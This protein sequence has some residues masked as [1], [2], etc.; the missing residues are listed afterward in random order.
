MISF[1]NLG[2]YGRL[3]NQMF[4]Y[5]ALR[6]IAA[7]NN[8]EYS[9]PSTDI[10]LK[11]AF[12]IPETQHNNNTTIIDKI[13][14]FEFDYNFFKNCPDNVDILGYFQTEKYFQHIK[15][16]I[17]KV[18]TFKHVYKTFC[19]NYFEKFNTDKKIA[20]H[21]R[22]SDYLTLSNYFVN[23][24]LE[25]YIQGLTFLNKDLKVFVFSD[26]VEWC[27]SESF[28]NN[29]RFIIPDFKNPILDLCAMSMCNYHI[30]ANS[31]YSW[32]GSWLAQSEKTIAP[33]DWFTGIYKEWNT[34][35][36]YL[37]NWIII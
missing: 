8:Y 2:W 6:G 7:Y 19:I 25:Y 15:D 17:L 16:E 34:K 31:S 21:I 36:L 18:F 3:G 9:I 10:V 4:Q 20:L 33:K 28:F 13:N 29:E 24:N 1:N 32:W 12:Y 26:D 22:R 37:N 11:D 14:C 30:I 35:D 5:A 23:L 27:T